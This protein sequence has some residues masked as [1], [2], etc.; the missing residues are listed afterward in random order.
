[1][2]TINNLS[3]GSITV[4]NRTYSQVLICGE[5]VEE[6]DENKLEATFG[7]SHRLGD[8]EIQKLLAGQPRAIIIGTGQEGVLRVRPEEAEAL[9]KTGAELF[10]LNTPEAVKKYQELKSQG[11]KINALF[12][13]TC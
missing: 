6:R 1:M 9:R 7:T 2:V 4:D 5:E 3:W 11:L 8:W 12:H 13:T 10:L